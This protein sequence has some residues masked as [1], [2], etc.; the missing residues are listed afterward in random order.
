MPLSPV[1]FYHIVTLLEDFKLF[2]DGSTDSSSEFYNC[3]LTPQAYWR[4]SQYWPYV[5]TTVETAGKARIIEGWLADWKTSLHRP[6]TDCF[7]AEQAWDGKAAFFVK[8]MPFLSRFL[9]YELLFKLRIS[10]F[11]LKLFSVDWFYLFCGQDVCDISAKLFAVWETTGWGGS[12][13]LQS[14]KINQLKKFPPHSFL[15]LTNLKDPTRKVDTGIT[16]PSSLNWAIVWP[17]NSSTVQAESHKSTTEFNLGWNK[18]S[19]DSF[20]NRDRYLVVSIFF[21]L[22]H[23]LHSHEA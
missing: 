10:L 21:A 12:A 9:N 16:L 8:S 18:R 14:T 22:F 19:D 2:A 20:L 6:T 13:K 3:S 11:F 5:L 15:D 17:R 23:Q 7:Q 1:F 4:V